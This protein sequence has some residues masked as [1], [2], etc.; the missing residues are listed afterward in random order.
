MPLY[1]YEFGLNVIANGMNG[2]GKIALP[3]ISDRK[4]NEKCIT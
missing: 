4:Q 3:E 2:D 1:E